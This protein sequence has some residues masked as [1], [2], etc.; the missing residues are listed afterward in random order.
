MWYRNNRRPC[1]DWQEFKKDFVKFFL[2]NRYFEKPGDQIHQ[3]YQQQ[4]EAFKPYALPMQNL[5]RHTE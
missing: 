2:R 1:T 3:T 5:K 4:G